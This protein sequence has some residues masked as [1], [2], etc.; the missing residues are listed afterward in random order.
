MFRA[1]PSDS[2]SYNQSVVAKAKI[3]SAHKDQLMMI[4]SNYFSRSACRDGTISALQCLQDK[5][6]LHDKP[7][8]SH[9]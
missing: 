5:V 4:M 3:A 9:A 2:R 8:T 1:S 7:K 6:C